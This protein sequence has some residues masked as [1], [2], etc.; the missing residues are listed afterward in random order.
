MKKY[1]LMLALATGFSSTYPMTKE[2]KGRISQLIQEIAIFTA[3]VPLQNGPA[4]DAYFVD[5]KATIRSYIRRGRMLLHKYPN[6]PV[7]QGFAPTC[8]D[9]ERVLNHYN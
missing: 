8:D 6:D 4:F 7:A 5:R 2:D 3:N 9:M 1:I